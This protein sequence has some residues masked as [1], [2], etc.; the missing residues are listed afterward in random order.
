MALIGLDIGTTGCKAHIFDDELQL[1]GSESREYAVDIPYPDWAEQDAENVWSLARECIKAG[2]EKTNSQDT[3]KAIG[4]SVQGEAVT[5]VD[6]KGRAIRATILGMDTRTDAQNAELKERFGAKSLFERTGMPVHTCNTL[7]KLMWI[8]A[9]EPDV[10][11]KA[12]QF[13]LYE[14]FVIRKMTG[15]AFIS[16]CLASRTQLYDLGKEDWSEEILETLGL[17]KRR[18]AKVAPS[19]TRAGV[20]SAALA[21]ELGLNN[22]PVV[23]VGGHDQACGALGAGLIEPGLAMVSTGT[24]EVVEVA[25][26]TP[27]LNEALFQANMSV[28]EHT[29]PGLF[30]VMTLNQSGGFMLRWF[31]DTFCEHEIS[32]AAHSQ[33]DAYDLILEGA[34]TK[35]SPIMILPHFFGSG[36]PYFDTRS[37]GAIVGLTFGTTKQDLAKAII[38]GLTLELRVNLDILKNGGITIDELR[39]IGGGAKSSLWLQLKADI[40]G[41]PVAVPKV[42]EAAG[43]GAAVLGG[44]AA[45]VFANARDAIRQHLVIEKVYDPDPE[46]QALF[47]KRYKTYQELYPAVKKINHQL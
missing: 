35:P 13:L 32:Q 8:K 44:V 18:L 19:G 41:I 14:D 46:N 31:R 1:L 25:I 17:E 21:Q 12:H 16:K 5:A 22:Q 7:P 34:D 20:M 9:H 45:G 15:E 43:M 2:V 11:N 3:I 47:E 39:A 37:K 6:E 30:V 24:A 4:F 38:E 40:T 23:G 10:W 28:Y 29:F 36:T 27:M 33:R 42:T 26:E